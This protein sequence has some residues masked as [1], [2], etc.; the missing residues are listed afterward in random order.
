[1][2]WH[3]MVNTIKPH[4]FRIS[5]PSGFGT[6]WLVSL[7]EK[8]SLCAIAT[9]AHVIDYAHSWELPIRIYHADSRHHMLL[10][11]QD[12]AIYM[13]TALDTAAIVFDGEFLSLPNQPMLLIQQDKSVKQGVEIGWLGYPGGIN[14]QAICFFSGR[15]S[16]YNPK[17]NQYL[18]DGVAING[19]S[20]GPVFRSN[21]FAPELI[22]VVSAYIA[23]KSTGGTLPGLAVVKNVYQYHDIA[24]RF[25]NLDEAQTDQ[26]PPQDGPIEKKPITPYL[27]PL[28]YV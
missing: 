14:Y 9:A 2:E 6:G 25:R 8:T 15:V 16:H 21:G 12:R 4:I 26:S 27:P 3:D 7:S 11:P 24:R 19:V 10:R 22:G 13:D 17:M 18:V 1:M 28:V 20:G 5:T 23:N